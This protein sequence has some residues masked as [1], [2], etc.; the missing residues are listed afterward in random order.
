MQIRRLILCAAALALL[1]G[2]IPSL[3]QQPAAPAPTTAQGQLVRV[4]TTARTIAIK[5]DAD[6]QML[7]TYNDDTKVTGSDSEVAGL[8][9]M[10]G[11]DVK[12]EY[13]KKGQEN[14]A[15]RIEVLKKPSV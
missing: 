14:I 3:A 4:D 10:S 7:F 5:T 6:A 8:A 12:I 1:V 11:T 15:T 2:V 13:V 9:T